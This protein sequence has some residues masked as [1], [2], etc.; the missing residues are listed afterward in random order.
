MILENP[1]KAALIAGRRQIG[2]WAALANPYTTEICAGAGF[3]WL[4]LDAEHA[5]NDIRSL[6]SQLQAAAPY[7]TTSVVRPCRGDVHMIKQILDIGAQNLL[8][9]MIE[10]AEEAMLMVGQRAIRPWY[11]WCGK[12]SRPSVTLEPGAALPRPSG[13]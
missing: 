8:V 5:P 4:L 7:K 2:L 6:L 13:C 1:F 12:C 9:P 11:P 3:D 10:T